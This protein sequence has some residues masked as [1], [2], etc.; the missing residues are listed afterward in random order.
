[1]NTFRTTVSIV[2]VVLAVPV[3]AMTGDHVQPQFRGT[4][5]PASAAC[6]SPVKVVID[7]NRV[8]FVNGAQRADFDKLEQCFGCLGQGA[9]EVVLLSTDKMGDSPWSLT[10]DGSKKGKTAVTA[11]FSNDK[12]L[13]GRFPL[14]TGPLKKCS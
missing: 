10:L 9:G 12:R 1:M 7:A 13:G 14:G 3:L 4:W 8:T 5:V 11:D 6:T 2:A